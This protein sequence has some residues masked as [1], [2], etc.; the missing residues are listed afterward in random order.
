MF[1]LYYVFLKSTFSALQESAFSL[2]IR[3]AN[4]V[5]YQY[6]KIQYL[7][8]PYHFFCKIQIVTKHSSLNPSII[9]SNG[10]SELKMMY[11]D[12]SGH[13]NTHFLLFSEYLHS[14]NFRNM[15]EQA[16]LLLLLPLLHLARS[17][18][19][20]FE[21]NPIFRLDLFILQL[22]YWANDHVDKNW[23]PKKIKHIGPILLAQ[24]FIFTLWFDFLPPGAG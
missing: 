17:C 20:H 24:S 3:N 7:H 12:C 21:E 22:L 9:T 11:L 23:L 8:K 14:W 5:K 2:T 4:N 13:H 16:T 6:C 15:F 10:Q 19:L 18:L 1:S